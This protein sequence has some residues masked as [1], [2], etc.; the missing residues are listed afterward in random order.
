MT[1]SRFFIFMFA[2]CFC[3]QVPAQEWRSELYAA[4]WNPEVKTFYVDKF[5][6]DFSYAGYHRGEKNV[7][8]GTGKVI[9]VSK[10]P[11]HIQ[12]NGQEDVT[13][14]LQRV[15]DEAPR[16]D[17]PVVIYLPAGIYRL[18][19]QKDKDYCLL[20]QRSEV[21]LRGAGAGKTFLFNSSTDMRGKDIVKIAASS[22]WKTG[23]KNKQ[24]ITKDL[25]SPARVIPVADA[26]GFRKGD[27]VIVR[28]YIDNSWIADHG[29]LEY[30]RDGGAALGG[31]MYCREVLSVD[32]QKNELVL[33]IPIRYSLLQQ[34]NSVVYIAP[35][36]LTEVGIE[37]MSIGNR[38]SFGQGD[39]SEESYRQKESPSYN[40][41]DS[42]AV[43]M[44]QV[45]NGWIRNVRSY[46][47]E[48]NS[49]GAHLLSN[50][51]KLWQTANVSLLQCDFSRPQYG[52]GGGNGYMYRIMGNETLVSECAAHLS[53]HGFVLSGMNASGNVFFVAWT[54]IPALKPASPGVRK[55]VE[56]EAI[57]ICIL[58]TPTSLISAGWR[59]ASS[60]QAGESGEA[61]SY[62]V[63][64]PPIVRIG[65]S[66][67]TAVSPLPCR[68]SKV[69][70]V[71]L[72]ALPAI[73]RRSVRPSG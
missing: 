50:G 44:S 53:R 40:L 67:V 36:M 43:E 71:M 46:C 11:Y 38:Q 66:L 28:N 26:S 4:D 57:I 72:S 22:S 45:Y 34:Q 37:D 52:G 69:A 27:R 49:S 16:L 29:M 42:W 51:I 65:T 18:S 70:T 54:K 41:H 58:A 5:L 35:R 60:R 13:I 73:S 9:D 23:G 25:V 3:R 48:G 63:S 61:V 8:S 55:Q 32:K 20:I 64:L 59:T 7:P 62:M 2:F 6:Q 56:A 68:A 10:A 19:P 17:K 21:V 30:W 12:G 24:R 1:T 31:L 39:W 14:P 33:D 15:I 47:P